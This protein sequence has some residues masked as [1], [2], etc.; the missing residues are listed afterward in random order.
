MIYRMP[1]WKRVREYY[2]RAPAA[3]WQIRDEW[4]LDPYGWEYGAGI[5]MSPI[6]RA[7]WHDIR[8]EDLVLYPQFPVG[9]FFVDFGN[10]AAK[11]A[12][13][14]DGAAFHLDV[15]RDD[16][17]QAEIEG[18]GWTVYRFGGKECLAEPREVEDEHGHTWFELNAAR[19]DLRAIGE[20]HGIARSG[21]TEETDRLAAEAVFGWQIP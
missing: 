14:C 2:A 15:S 11:V 20:T 5:E 18:R 17:R 9:R 19:L 6:E 12:I 1:D 4:V 8:V 3:I 16:A 13:E 7:L 10:P 21:R